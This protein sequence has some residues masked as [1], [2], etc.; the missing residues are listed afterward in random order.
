[1]MVTYKLNFNAHIFGQKLK[2]ACQRFLLTCLSSK[3]AQVYVYKALKSYLRLLDLLSCMT[4]CTCSGIKYTH[5]KSTRELRRRWPEHWKVLL[6]SLWIYCHHHHSVLQLV[7]WA[8]CSSHQL[9]WGSSCRCQD[10]VYPAIQPDHSHVTL[11]R[12]PWLNE[13]CG[14][15][16]TT[17]HTH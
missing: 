9:T 10:N 6:L 1:M 5:W 15:V 13:I 2:S 4:K 8:I 16:S 12:F 11:R 17:D 3:S 14:L 7:P